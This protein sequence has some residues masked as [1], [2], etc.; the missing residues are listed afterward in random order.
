MGERRSD[1]KISSRFKGDYRQDMDWRM[2][3][4]LTTY[5]HHSELQVITALSLIS[6][7]YKSS[8]HPLSLF[9][10]V[11]SS[12]LPWQ[13]LL[14]VEILQLHALRFY[15]HMLSAELNSLSNDLVVPV[16]GTDYIE[17]T[18]SNRSC[19]VVEACSLC[20]YI[21]TAVVSLFVS[22]S[23]PSSG[24]ICHNIKEGCRLEVLGKGGRIIL[25][26]T[27]RK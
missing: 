6:T 2:D 15:L 24:S 23:L 7:L 9:P 20:R 18:V 17:N 11:S 22:R 13:R 26:W 21:A 8:Q 16:V 10:A 27:L 1:W 25:K 12:G 3:S 5:T 19:I 4:S 14:T